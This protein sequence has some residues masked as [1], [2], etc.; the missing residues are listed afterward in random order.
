MSEPK[1]IL[2]GVVFKKRQISRTC[3]RRRRGCRP[4]IYTVHL[5]QYLHVQ[6][7]LCRS[8]ERLAL[9]HGSKAVVP[10]GRG[11][12]QT[13]TSVAN[14]LILIHAWTSSI[15]NNAA[16]N[17]LPLLDTA[18]RDSAAAAGNQQLICLRSPLITRDNSDPRTVAQDGGGFLLNSITVRLPA[19]KYCLKL[20]PL[21]AD[22]TRDE[23]S[24]AVCSRGRLSDHV[25]LVSLLLLLL[26][27]SGG[28]MKL[29]PPVVG[30][31]PVPGINVPG[32]FG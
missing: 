7:A 24:S 6:L 29:A 14:E 26:F 19:P 16:F 30:L 27:T 25:L 8:K 5:L 13:A 28:Y 17:M 2:K 22:R 18:H 23:E 10:L 1:V 3:S 20:L 21:C 31:G 15:F 4:N 12:V 9:E 11:S 32:Y